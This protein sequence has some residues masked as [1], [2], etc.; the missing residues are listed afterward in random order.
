[1]DVAI[2]WANHQNRGRRRSLAQAANQM[3]EHVAVGFERPILAARFVGAVRQD[4]QSRVAP[5]D[6][7][8]QRLR[9]PI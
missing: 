3:R 9:I 5:R 2:R 6:I 4:D 1:M 8:A 7:R